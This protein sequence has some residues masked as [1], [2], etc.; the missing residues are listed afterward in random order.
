MLIGTEFFTNYLS[1]VNENTMLKSIVLLSFHILL[2]WSRAVAQIPDSLVNHINSC[3]EILQQHSLYSKRVDW[4]SV[5]SAVLSQDVYF[6]ISTSRIGNKNKKPLPDVPV[7]GNDAFG[8]IEKDI[9]VQAAII[10]L[11]SRK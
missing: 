3:L 11:N 5:K 9:V 6:L 7:K 2:A 1:M 10:W 4:P 8:S